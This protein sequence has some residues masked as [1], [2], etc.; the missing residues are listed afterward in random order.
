MS[1]EG[2]RTFQMGH[3]EFRRKQIALLDHLEEFQAA[4][5]WCFKLEH[6]QSAPP[7]GGYSYGL[8]HICEQSVG[9]YISNGALIAAMLAHGFQFRRV[10]GT[11]NCIFFVT[12]RSIE[13][14]R[15]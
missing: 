4:Y 6:R 12:M 2:W 1:Y 5:E 9:R 10:A 3:D 13:R 7:Y 15:S 11:A 14:A 8:K